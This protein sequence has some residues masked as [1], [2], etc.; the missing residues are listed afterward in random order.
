MSTVMLG[1]E[2]AKSMKEALIQEVELLKKEGITPSLTIIRVGAREDD[3]AYERSAKKRM[4]LVGIDCNVLELAKDISQEEFEREFAKVNDD[5]EV[6]GILLFRPLPDGLDEEPVKMMIDPGKDAD[7]M[8][9]VNSVKVFLGE[10]DGYAPCTAQA[11]MEILKH[12]NIDVTG[13]KVT[14]VGRSMVVGK[15]L[16]ML[17][18]KNNATITVCHTRTK[19]LKEEC[20]DADILV[21]CAGNA[22]MITADM[23]KDGAVVVDVGINIDED[24]QMCGDV[25]YENVKEKA[26]YITPV[27]RG[28]GSVTTS[29]LASHVVRGAKNRRS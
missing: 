19:D 7:C 6:D 27:P 28:V 3:L 9:P 4:E 20:R 11:V 23:V 16:S 5:P 24:G 26:S 15:P 17:M 14:I 8:G 12:F 22:K 29:V 2:V 21:A 25:D 10:E 13:K 18:L 1:T